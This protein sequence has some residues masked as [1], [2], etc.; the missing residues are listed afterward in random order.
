MRVLI[1]EDERKIANA[2]KKALQRESY[3]VDVSYDG[4][5]GWTMASTEPYDVM[6]I[7]RMIPGTYDGV[8][9]IR[10]LRNAEIHTPILLLT[11]LGTISDKTTGLDAG[12]D[13]YLV[14]PFALEEL[15]A[16]VRALVRRSKT[17][18]EIVLT[19]G[20]LSLNTSTFVATRADKQLTLTQKEYSLL[21]YL[22]RNQGRILSKEMIMNHVWDYDATILP[23]TVEAHIKYL[24][25]K[26]DKKPLTPLIHTVRGF[27]YKLE[28]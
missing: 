2:L 27:G 9:I 4:D 24:R 19:A 3:A 25:K 11:A 13:D 21:E 28:V 17:T 10:K 18:D 22:M 23:N 5:D 1:I 15:L 12:A 26:I 7:D 8:A 14:K 20:D 16:R 6:I